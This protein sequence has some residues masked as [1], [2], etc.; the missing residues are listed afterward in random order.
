MIAAATEMKRLGLASKPMIVVPNHLVEQWG[1]AFLTLY[2]HAHVFVAS[3]DAFAAGT[4]QKAMYR[5]AT[6]NYDGVIVSHK[7]CEPHR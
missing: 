1:A 7:F 5:I 3:K 6:G 4:R 2:P